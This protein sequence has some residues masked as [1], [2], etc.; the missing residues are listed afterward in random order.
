M[1]AA[2]LLYMSCWVSVFCLL[3]SGF[4]G[5]V[6]HIIIVTAVHPLCFCYVCCASSVYLLGLLYV[7]CVFS[8]CMLYVCFTI[9]ACL[10]CNSCASAA[11]MPKVKN[12][13]MSRQ[14]IQGIL[15]STSLSQP[16]SCCPKP[17]QVLAK[18]QTGIWQRDSTECF[19][20]WLLC[21][22][23]TANPAPSAFPLLAHCRTLRMETRGRKYSK[24]PHHLGKTLK[25]KQ[26]EVQE[27][28]DWWHTATGTS[29]FEE[30]QDKLCSRHVMAWEGS[31][32]IHG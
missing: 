23:C 24:N 31:Y 26:K 10:L 3:C 29:G 16:G 12:L 27:N 1:S 30:E 25:Q 11:V 15:G 18:I 2:H 5:C 8:E 14:L 32:N 6:L 19:W 28:I 13:W 20:Y 22:R 17:L 9:A 7:C 4:A 21:P